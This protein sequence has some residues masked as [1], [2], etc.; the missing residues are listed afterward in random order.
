MTKLEKG[1]L[2]GVDVVGD[3]VTKSEGEGV[4]AAADEEQEE[5]EEEVQV[6]YAVKRALEALMPRTDLM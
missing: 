6:R 3:G 2:A 5:E 4:T 1:E